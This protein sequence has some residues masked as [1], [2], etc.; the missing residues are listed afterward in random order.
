MSKVVLISGASRGIGRASALAFAKAGYR[1]AVTARKLDNTAGPRHRITSTGY[2]QG[3]LQETVKMI[4]KQ[5]GEAFAVPMDLLSRDSVKCALEAVLAQFGNVDVVINNAIYQGPDLNAPL[6]DLTP[7]TLEN[8][9]RAYISA[10]V[11]IAQTLIPLMLRQ[12]SGCIINITSGA[13]EKD[14]PIPASMGGWG[15]AYGAGKA[16][17][18]RLSG[19]ISREHGREGIRAFTVNPGVVNTETLRQTIGEKGVKGLGQSVAEPSQIADVLLWITDNAKADKLQ[20]KTIDAQRLA[21][22]LAKAR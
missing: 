1:V 14:P 3:S 22:D 6:L 15:Y 21:L 18:S 9:A 2:A 12:G 11:Q 10:P 17:V 19:I 16:A 7:Q 20:Y 8:V 13:G 4:E 5:G